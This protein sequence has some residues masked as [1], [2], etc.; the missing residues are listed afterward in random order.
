MSLLLAELR[1]L[2]S[3]RAV[4]FLLIA[5]FALAALITAGVV[6]EGRPITAEDRAYGQEQYERD[7]ADCEENPRRYGGGRGFECADVMMQ[8]EDYVYRQVL[9]PGTVLEGLLVT[10]TTLLGLVALVVGTTFV[11]AEWTSGSMSNLMLFEPRRSRV[12]L[13]KVVAVVVVVTA[14]ATAVLG[15]VVGGSLAAAVS[16]SD[17]SWGGTRGWYAAYATLRGITLVVAVALVGVALTLALRST[18]ATVGLAFGYALVGEAVFRAVA[19]G[20]VE[21]W[22]LSSHLFAFLQ[23]KLELYGQSF[24]RRPD[25]TVLHL[26]TSALYLGALLLVLLVASWLIFRRRDI[27]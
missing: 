23:G 16:W 27:A 10:L 22:L 20:A 9:T 25:V 21:P 15:L 13:A 4:V 3:R 19:P 7:I 8:P 12:W 6:W 17:A 14:F 2:L 26:Q 11:G 24:G 1:R 18:I 5:G